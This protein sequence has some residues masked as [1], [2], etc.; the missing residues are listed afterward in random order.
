M[1]LLLQKSKM[2]K[3]KEKRKKISK[4]GLKSAGN[5][6]RFIKPYKW[7]WTVGW[8]FLVLSSI[9]SMMFPY[10]LGKLLGAENTG[11]VS[12]QNSSD[13]INSLDN[14]NTV[15]V[16]LFV[17]FGTQALFSFFRI[18]LFTR[19]TESA[20]KDLRLNAFQKLIS[21]PMDFFNKSKAGE[22]SSRIATDIN[23]LQ[24]TLNTTIAEFVRQVFTIGIGIAFLAYFSIK[25]A[26]IMLAVIPIMAIIA[27]L[28]GRYIKKL[29]KKAQDEAASSNV[30]LEESLTGISVVKS[31]T[32]EL[33]E[34]AKYSKRINNIK[35]LQIKA[36]AWRGV[37]V[38][39]LIF[40]MFGA[41]IF[42]IWQGVLMVQNGEISFGHFASFILY[43]VFIGASFGALPNLYAKI[44][45]AIGATENLMD[46]LQ[47][48]GEPTLQKDVPKIELKGKVSFN[49]VSFSYPQRP[50]IK[51]L[52]G[53]SFDASKGQTIALVGASGAGKSTISNLLMGYYKPSDGQII[54]DKKA[55][56]D[57]DISALRQ[58]IGVVPQEVILFGGSIAENIAYGKPDASESEIIEAAK[59]ANAW[60][61]IEQF[62]DGLHTQV[63]DRGIQLSGGQRQRVAI[64]R[65]VLKDP[66]ILILDEATS[67]LDTASEKLVQDALNR[68]MKNRT[69]FVIA[70][71]LST[72]KNADQILVLENGIIAEKGT[73]DKLLTNSEGA[74]TKLHNIQSE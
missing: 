51:V 30:V 39:F 28:F 33:F 4:E 26:L 48:K 10:L 22:L 5:F 7:T 6:L 50:D 41:I 37:F 52:K 57:Y 44:Q 29:S 53:L 69:S 63:G 2:R 8:L 45:Q 38:S 36:G 23:L 60:E 35:S 16:L 66:E 11:S 49:N 68:L 74:Y 15:V 25:L 56:E 17:T 58:N 1:I 32:N 20:L 27:V 55:I 71:R 73:H 40:C 64:A 42:V 70:H 34:I 18:L 9:T 67:A 19:V 54:F 62:P 24:E 21:L 3:K 46:I 43:T 65:A 13:L 31:F 61:F 14:V 59:Q 72:I 47:E 12:V